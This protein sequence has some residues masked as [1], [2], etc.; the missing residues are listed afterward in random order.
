MRAYVA[1]CRYVGSP[2]QTSLSEAGQDKFF[3]CV[4]RSS[5]TA[6]ELATARPTAVTSSEPSTVDTLLAAG[7][8]ESEVPNAGEARHQS[9]LWADQGLRWK[10]AERWVVSIG[11]KIIKVGLAYC[12][13]C[14]SG[15]QHC[16]CVPA[17]N[18]HYCVRCH[19]CYNVLRV[20]SLTLM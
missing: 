13:L 1:A 8:G 20:T 4:Q 19:D 5:V 7:L 16:S 14:L 15:A 3:Y 11:S 17:G 12:V 10:E 6:D 9:V 18:S 2:Y